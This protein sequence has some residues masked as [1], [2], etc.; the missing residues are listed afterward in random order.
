LLLILSF[1]Q[2]SAIITEESLRQLFA[3]FGEVVDAVIC[4]SSIDQRTKRQSGY[5]FI[6][7]P[8]TP[9]GIKAS[10]RAAQTLMDIMIDDVNYKCKISHQLEQQLM[11]TNSVD[12]V[13]DSSDNCSL[14][15]E[16]PSIYLNNASKPAEKYLQLSKSSSTSSMTTMVNALP[17]TPPRFNSFTDSGSFNKSFSLSPQMSKDSPPFENAGLIR[18]P[19]FVN[20][21]IRNSNVIHSPSTSN[22]NSKALQSHHSMSSVNSMN[23][24]YE[25]MKEM[26]ISTVSM[27]SGNHYYPSLSV[28]NA[29]STL[30][31]RETG[32]FLLHPFFRPDKPQHPIG[33][34]SYYNNHNATSSLSSQYSP[35]STLPSFNAFNQPA[36]RSK[37]SN[38][39]EEQTI[40]Y[41]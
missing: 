27:D 14:P 38:D 33:S 10:F 21:P 3:Q 36:D 19:T 9:T 25:G 35:Q 32:P 18:G 26:N 41:T 7:F 39:S 34:V 28:S 15:T 2:I 23:E 8:G 12:Q 31:P 30:T 13:A 37:D 17:S 24:L 40:Q 20:Y 6:H 16:I 5:G 1:F 22:Q 29:S 4:K 11:R